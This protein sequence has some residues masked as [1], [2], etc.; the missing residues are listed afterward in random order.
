MHARA[1]SRAGS[2][3]DSGPHAPYPVDRGATTGSETTSAESFSTASDGTDASNAA[4]TAAAMPLPDV[5]PER[6][7]SVSFA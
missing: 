1:A 6:Q 7:K 3:A 2:R 5:G 4:A